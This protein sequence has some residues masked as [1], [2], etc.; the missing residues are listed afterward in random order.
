MGD[1]R[2]IRTR[3]TT[4]ASRLART[5]GFRGAVALLCASTALLGA[6]LMCLA[7]GPAAAAEPPGVP[8]QTPTS[9]AAHTYNCPYEHGGCGSFGHLSPAVLTS[10]P[11]DTPLGADAPRVRRGGAEETI[12]TRRGG[13]AWARAPGLHE[14]Q[15]LRR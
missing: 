6:L 13:E 4:R 12:G 7:P 8:P 15:V 14:L 10:S 11:P 2:H 5:G 9:A 1:L 3:R